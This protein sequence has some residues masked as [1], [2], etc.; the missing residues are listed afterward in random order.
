MSLTQ[1][2]DDECEEI[3]SKIILKSDLLEEEPLIYKSKT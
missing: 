1:E 2:L 3:G